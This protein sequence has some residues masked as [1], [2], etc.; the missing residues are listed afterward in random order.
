MKVNLSTGAIILACLAAFLIDQLTSL[1]SIFGYIVSALLLVIILF[2]QIQRNRKLQFVHGPRLILLDTFLVTFVIILLVIST[3]GL[4][5]P[6]L[7][8]IHLTAVGFALFFSFEIA[9]TWLGIA[10]LIFVGQIVINPEMRLLVTQSIGEI[11]LYL[12]SFMVTLPILAILTRSYR[13]KGI[14]SQLLQEMLDLGKTRED[15]IID[16]LDELIFVVD[17][18]LKIIS[19]NQA[20]Q[21]ALGQ[22]G[23]KLKDQLFFKVVDLRNQ[24]GNQV[25]KADLLIEQSLIDKTRHFIPKVYLYLPT[26]VQ[27][28]QINI[29]IDPVVGVQNVVSQVVIML[30]LVDDSSQSGNKVIVEQALKRQ[31]VMIDLLKNQLNKLKLSTSV[32]ELDLIERMEN[33]IYDLTELRDHIIHES[34]NFPDIII[35]CQQIIALKNSLI[36]LELPQ[37][38]QTEIVQYDARWLKVLI[39]KLV[40]ISLFLTASASKVKILVIRGSDSSKI[41][42]EVWLS[43]TLTPSQ[44]D[45]L[46]EPYFGQLVL[47]DMPDLPQTG[48]EGVIAKEIAR[49]LNIPLKLDHQDDQIV[50]K[51]ILSRYPRN[52]PIAF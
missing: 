22:R 8:L 37:T 12:L 27:P 23:E 14:L 42:L 15:S 9:L 38:A 1:N 39:E 43:A 36:K 4:L 32:T 31:R 18:N 46:F 47:A 48:L 35:L 13:L 21:R 28:S 19:S 5:S 7:V 30:V 51:V 10:L 44:L 49:Q 2:N 6:F 11:S 24:L 29:H 25:N 17:R 26:Q 33:D 41:N 40:E 50:F 20:A 34:T 16:E 45:Q 52:Q 3:G